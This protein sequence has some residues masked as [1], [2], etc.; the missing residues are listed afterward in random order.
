MNSSSN[1][2]RIPLVPGDY[3]GDHIVDAADYLLWRKTFGSR[4]NLAADGN[5]DGVVNE[6]DYSIWRQRY[7]NPTAGAGSLFTSIPEPS[8][9]TIIGGR[10]VPVFGRN[11]EASP[12]LAA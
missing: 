9:A 11:S 6:V 7:G 10:C 4:T 1:S 8:T 2:R 12:P 3:N 5:H